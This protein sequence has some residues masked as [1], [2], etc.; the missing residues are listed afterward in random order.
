MGG[1]SPVSVSDA[2]TTAAAAFAMDSFPT[3]PDNLLASLPFA[4]F[5]IVAASQQVVAGIN[6]RLEIE[7]KDAE[8]VCVNHAAITVY[9]RFGTQ[10]VTSFENGPCRV[11]VAL[12]PRIE[13]K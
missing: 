9:D 11:D 1:Y 8:G 2:R 6:Y 12:K 10:T 3:L 7:M 4:S 13:Y 5:D